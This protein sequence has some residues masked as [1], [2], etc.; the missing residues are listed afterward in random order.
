ME[1]FLSLISFVLVILLIF[2]VLSFL[3]Y[4]YAVCI[5]EANIIKVYHEEKVVYEGAKAFVDIESGGMTTTVT[6]Y[7]QLFPLT[8]TK[9]IYSSSDIRVEQQ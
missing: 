5:G 4:K 9:A 7:K 6:I 8:I 2:F 1:D 3:M